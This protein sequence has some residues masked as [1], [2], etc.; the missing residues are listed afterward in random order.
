MSTDSKAAYTA[1]KEAVPEL[2]K[3]ADYAELYGLDFANPAEWTKA[4]E[5]VLHKYLVA[6]KN[7]VEA[8]KTQLLNTLKWRKEF[9]PLE[10]AK[11]SHSAD[12]DKL[13]VITK[14]PSGKVIT[15]NLY[16]AIT[17]RQEV[18]G[19]LD[20]FLRWRVGL[21]ERGIALLDLTSDEFD[22]MDQ[23]HD[24]MD[25]SFL[26]M[27]KETKTA[28]SRT[29]KLFQ[30]YY[31][32]FLSRKYFVNVPYIMTWVFSFAKAF[33][34]K[35]TAAKM[36]IIGNGKDLKY[37]LGD[38]IP[39]AYGGRAKGFSEIVAGETAVKT[40]VSPENGDSAPKLQAT[41]T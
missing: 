8:A 1:L 11:E 16:G 13:G 2:I 31:P 22:T 4:H 24:Y 27:D 9:K 35:E 41:S 32:E 14:S 6:N 10:A 3:K 28:S 19:K 34:A 12:L 37:D 15:W 17:N 18:F 33:M 26:R 29:I 23:V 25:V 30:D 40:P 20:Q 36:Q 5:K 7:D 21:M 38:W 39:K